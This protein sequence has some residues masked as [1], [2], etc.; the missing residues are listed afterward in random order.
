MAE[1]QRVSLLPG[2]EN[3]RHGKVTGDDGE[4]RIVRSFHARFGSVKMGGGMTARTRLAYVFR[5]GR[6][7]EDVGDVKASAGDREAV[8]EA[9]DRIRATARVRRGKTAE[10][11]LATQV[12]ELPLECT[13]EQREKCAQAFVDDWRERGHQAVAV[14]HVHGEEHEQPHL[15][16]EIAARPVHADG[17]VDRS[18]RL[19]AGDRPREAVYDERQTVADIVNRTCDPD[20]PYHPGGFR[21]IGIERQPRTRM[22][23][24]KFRKARAEIRKARAAN[25]TER[26]AEIEAAAYTLSDAE[27]G[28]KRQAREDRSAVVLVFKKAGLPVRMTQRLRLAITEAGLQTERERLAA[29]EQ[30]R[31]DAAKRARAAEIGRDGANSRVAELKAQLR[32]MNER[33]TK[34]IT[35]WHG[36][37]GVEPPDL[38][39]VEGQSEAW[40]NMRAWEAEAKEQAAKAEIE[41]ALEDERARTQGKIDAAVR[42]ALA[43]GQA[44][45]KAAERPK[46]EEPPVTADLPAHEASPVPAAVPAERTAALAPGDLLE[47]GLAA[48]MRA[49]AKWGAKPKDASPTARA[50][51]GIAGSPVLMFT[52]A[53][54]GTW[55]KKRQA[56]WRYEDEG[57]YAGKAALKIEQAG[58]SAGADIPDWMAAAEA[59]A[60]VLELPDIRAK[61]Y[62]G[63]GDTYLGQMRD[64]KEHGQGAMAHASGDRYEGGWNDGR[65]HGQGVHTAANGTRY[66]GE[67]NDGRPHGQGA[68]AHANGA[69]YE[70]EWKDAIMNGRGVL[71]TASGKRYEGEWKD[72]LEH[73]HGIETYPDGSR[74]EGGWQEGKRHGPGIEIAADGKR[75]EGVWEDG[76]RV[77]AAAK[78][79]QAEPKKTQT[80]TSR[81]RGAEMD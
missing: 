71:T 56:Q 72:G 23:A 9:A 60:Q 46:A 13:P 61:R 24:V 81:Y 67:W 70:G 79:Q 34:Y 39:S 62:G 78:E 73:G 64:G 29:A 57:R 51:E 66:E 55:K 3:N 22:P 52:P 43:D 33:Q 26:E 53:E 11:I 49:L 21:D 40:A 35:D 31:K 32:E 2:V 54:G 38:E 17:A 36:E 75:I 27:R 41:A 16:V 77:E 25:D 1:P 63:D 80:T 45:Q 74:Y 44:R 28:K 50:L 5:E 69:R 14:V 48:E 6:H 68:M 59:L 65:K 7:A 10:R 8:I 15:H 42:L 12:I 4:A 76:K 20:P 37:R 47:A 30:A 19:W 18:A 58:G